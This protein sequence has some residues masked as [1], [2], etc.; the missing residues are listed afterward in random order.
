[1]ISMF[2]IFVWQ[3]IAIIDKYLLFTLLTLFLE[4]TDYIGIQTI[5]AKKEERGERAP[6]RIRSLNIPISNIW[7]QLLKIKIILVFIKNI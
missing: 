4:S 6:V 1:M 3:F 5:Y 2:S 7:S